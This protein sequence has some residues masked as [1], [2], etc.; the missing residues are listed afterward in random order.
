M[1]YYYVKVE[2]IVGKTLYCHF[3]DHHG[4]SVRKKVWSNRLLKKKLKKNTLLILVDKEPIM[5]I[6]KIPLKEYKFEG[7]AND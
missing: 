5:F 3:F 7:F 6:N 4:Y 2:K 1:D